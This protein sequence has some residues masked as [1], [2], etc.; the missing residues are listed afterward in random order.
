MI[1]KHRPIAS[2]VLL[3]ACY[4]F[5]CSY[6]MAEDAGRVEGQLS[7]D[8]AAEREPENWISSPRA[9]WP[10][11]VLTHQA[12]FQ[13]H[14][15]LAGASGFLIET[16]G[17]RVF[18]AT[19]A[20]LIGSAGGVEPEIPLGK[21]NS[22]IRSWRMFPRTMNEAFVEITSLGVEGL[23][24]P[25]LDWLILSLKESQQLPA[26]PLKLRRE[27]VKVGESVY[28]IGCP[29]VEAD[30]S[31]NVYRGTVTERAHGDRF[32][33]TLDPP[34]DIRGF[35]G[36]PIIDTDGYLVGVMTVWFDPKTSG[37]VFLEAGG[38]DVA[39]IYSLLHAAP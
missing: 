20:H 18:A 21:L 13:G 17:D 30:C 26:Y 28:L 24:G 5:G 39:S 6:E 32:R 9:E 23:E 14:T 7:P 3:L 25:N 16:P 33:Y 11:I 8:S 27:P 2:L 31:Q 4:F 29:Y 10:Q 19:A 35:S 34:V 38:E 37:G 36:A 15:P 1:T 22:R 12:E